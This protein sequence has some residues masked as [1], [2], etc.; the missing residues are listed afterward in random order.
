MNAIR[1]FFRRLFCRH[2]WDITECARY[3]ITNSAGRKV[4]EVTL[5]FLNCSKCGEDRIVPSDRTSEPAQEALK[6]QP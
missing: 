6:S 1:Q 5:T 2:E 4:G 3:A